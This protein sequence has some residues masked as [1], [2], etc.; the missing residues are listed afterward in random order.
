VRTWVNK[1][2]ERIE[3]RG[4]KDTV[5]YGIMISTDAQEFAYG[6]GGDYSWMEIEAWRAWQVEKYG[7][8]LYQNGNYGIGADGIAKDWFIFRTHQ[9]QKI[10]K[11]VNDAFQSRGMHTVFDSGSFTDAAWDRNTWGVPFSV[12]KF[13][14]DGMKQNPMPDYPANLQAKLLACTG[15]FSSVEWTYEPHATTPTRMANEFKRS[16]DNGVNDISFAFLAPKKIG[17][18]YSMSPELLEM[19][20]QIKESGHWDKKQQCSNNSTLIDIHL[21]EVLRRGSNEYKAAE[22]DSGHE[23]FVPVSLMISVFNLN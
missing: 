23:M 4:R 15:K 8:V 20:R 12:N 3:Q 2:A 21:S 7:R 9:Q 18:M 13:G 6:R 11:I 22:L 1:L 14:V 10:Y 17:N 5:L 16:I 19:V